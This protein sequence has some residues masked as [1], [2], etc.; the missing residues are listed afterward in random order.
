MNQNFGPAK[1]SIIIPALNKARNIADA[2][3]ERLALQV[4]TPIWVPEIRCF[5]SSNSILVIAGGI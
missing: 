3:S 4:A 1:I 5:K 2:I